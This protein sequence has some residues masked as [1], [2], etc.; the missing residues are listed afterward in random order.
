VTAVRLDPGQ[1]AGEIR[2]SAMKLMDS[3]GGVVYEWK[4][5]AAPSAKPPK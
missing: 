2:I 3:N 1:A 5:A 4:F